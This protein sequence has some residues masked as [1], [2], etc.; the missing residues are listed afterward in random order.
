MR[1]LL[2]A[3]RHAAADRAV[4]ESD[5]HEHALRVDHAVFAEGGA[6]LV[7]P[8]ARTLG[9]ARARTAFALMGGDARRLPASAP[10]SRSAETLA[11]ARDIG[12]HL[13]RPGSGGLEAIYVDGYAAPG[14]V[15]AWAGESVAAAGAIGTLALERG[16]L[17]LAAILAG[18]PCFVRDDGV[19]GI[20]FIGSPATHVT[21]QD[22]AFDIARRLA[23]GGA[24]RRLVEFGGAGV[25]S[26]SIT[27]RMIL[28][29]TSAEWGA[30]AALFPAD[31][32]T[33]AWLE[34]RGRRSDWR[35]SEAGDGG[36]D[37]WLEID[38]GQ[39]EPQF[40]ELGRPETARS[41][42]E[43]TGPDVRHVHIGPGATAAELLR[44]AHWLKGRELPSGVTLTI[45]PGSRERLEILER[46][47]ALRDLVAQGT[48]IES[49]KRAAVGETATGICCGTRPADLE[50]TRVRWWAASLES[51]AAAARTGRLSD[52]RRV[53][54]AGS[55]AAEPEFLVDGEARVLAPRGENDSPATGEGAGLPAVP[56]GEAL[57][58]PARGPVLLR[59]GDGVPT[60]QILP[61]GARIAP[62]AGD[63]GA[64]RAHAFESLDP[65]FCRQALA[66]GGGFVV[67]GA[68]LG[69]GPQ[70]QQAALVLVALGV[71]AV[72]ARSWEP[73]FRRLLLDAGSL[74]LSFGRAADLEAFA[75]GDEVELP[76]LPHGL[77]PG[78]PLV[79]RNLTRGSQ[80]DVR[81]ELDARAVAVA[82]SGGLLRYAA[83]LGG[84]A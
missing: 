34:S 2:A 23:P 28:A 59:C 19:L 42:S 62:L 18:A 79:V 21:G 11:A 36:V 33:R 46:A 29:G 6:R 68:G 27:D 15:V 45:V 7:L 65:D 75:A 40:A 38:L 49:A 53:L 17:E 8:A 81:H 71:R 58:G 60:E 70:G 12:I 24:G 69:R 20:R 32:V 64:L 31:D 5:G 10:A 3:V 72:I 39:V 47:G 43:G 74:P 55:R 1:G 73:G 14:R 80:L 83:G 35:K 54:R 82:R 26:L 77:E 13:V 44:F 48:A 56:M 16:E 51:C 67:A 30:A 78:R 52:P 63:I 57:A 9:V 61:W 76:T 66:A 37:E 50:A 41:L 22:V 25:T 4:A 84:G